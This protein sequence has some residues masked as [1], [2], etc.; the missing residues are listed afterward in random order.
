MLPQRK[1]RYDPVA[2]M[3]AALK[4]RKK[5]LALHRAG[6]SVQEIADYL[7]VSKQRASDILAKAKRD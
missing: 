4:R 7:G 6:K 3:D 5:V 2:V 1:K